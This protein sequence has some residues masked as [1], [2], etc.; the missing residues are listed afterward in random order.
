MIRLSWSAALK[1]LKRQLNDPLGL[2]MWLLIP[3]A[4][5]VLIT[6]A[7]GGSNGAAPTAL[8]LIVDEDESLA[9]GLLAG[10]FAQGALGDLVVA[11]QVT[12][13]SGLERI[14]S[15][16]GSALLIIPAGFGEAVINEEPATLE[17]VT[18]PAQRILPAILEDTLGVMVDGVF[19][20]H[21]LFGDQLRQL[22]QMI[23]SSGEQGPSDVDIAAVSVAINQAMA[24][25]S[26]SLF[27]PLL[28]VETTIEKEDSQGPDVSVGLLF[29]PGILILSLLFV[30]QGMSE[31][32]WKEKEQGTLRRVLSTP[33]GVLPLLVGKLVST[34]AIMTAIA[35]LG[36]LL[37]AWYHGLSMRLLPPAVG[38]T[39]ASGLVFFLAMLTLQLFAS[40]RRGGAILT[41]ALVFPLAML[42]GSFFPSE[43]MPAWMRVVGRYTPNG[44]AVE[45]LKDILLERADAAAILL[46]LALFAGAS[47]V[48]LTISIRRL[49]RTFAVN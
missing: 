9:S 44:L 25:L 21:R 32:I 35:L 31:D 11:E 13:D 3:L 1:D 12:R 27:P 20:L 10:A 18:N 41:G 34:V 22:T 49:S 40:T 15:G 7:T 29:L 38:W 14:D 42:G 4:I 5:G 43:A 2:L 36:L 23:E 19:Y 26:E 6:L 33:G 47:A 17:L 39:M 8:L 45:H 48:L 37:G 28:Q 16:D 46:A 24:G 30:A